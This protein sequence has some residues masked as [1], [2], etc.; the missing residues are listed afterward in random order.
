MKRVVIF[1]GT[2]QNNHQL[3]YESLIKRLAIH[4]YVDFIVGSDSALNLS[5]V[6][7]TSFHKKKA[8]ESLISFLKSKK[9][10]FK[11]AD[12][13]VFEELY[14]FN[15]SVLLLIIFFG[16][17]S[18]QIVH[19]ANKFLDRS[20]KLNLKSWIAFV[21]F[22]LIKIFIKGIVV[23]SLSVKE[24]ILDNKLFK[25]DVYYI[26]FNDTRID[27]CREASPKE[28]VK[29]T[30]PGTVNTERRNY[31]VFLKVFLRILKE[32]PES[33][34]SLCLLGKI[35]K[36]GFEEREL[37]E[38]I[39]K[40]NPN[41]VKVWKEFI[42]KE[43]YHNELLNSDYLIGNI[44]IDYTEHNV[45]EVYGQ[46]KETGVLF[47]M[48]QYKIPTL[49][50]ENYNFSKIYTSNII[51]YKNT[52]NHLYNTI[53]TLLEHTNDEVKT[54][55]LSDHNAYVQHEIDKLYKTFLTC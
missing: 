23:V 53:F 47:L 9:V 38:E 41:V 10:Y 22:K 6:D 16:H 55:Q 15:I 29:F 12:L 26:P 7:N 33:N 27:Y 14:T 17:K 51:T 50:P 35:I 18:L 19:N 46:T 34:V 30:I 37:I 11:S 49:F 28:L 40:I 13:I 39:N 20:V 44:N 25:K 48:L 8:D 43:T 54:E 24:Y 42:D 1:T 4:S 31:K 52:E 5:G 32:N 45:K 2:Y 3:F 36:M 21:F